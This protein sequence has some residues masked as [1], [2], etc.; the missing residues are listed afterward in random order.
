MRIANS[1]AT[2]HES[3]WRAHALTFRLPFVD[4]NDMRKPTF[5]LSIQTIFCSLVQEQKDPEPQLIAE[6]ICRL[7]GKQLQADAYSWPRSYRSQGDAREY[8]E[9]DL[10]HLLQDSRHH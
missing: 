4:K 1:Y 10:A 5:V 3:G 8:L 9:R 7:S 2:C 6:A